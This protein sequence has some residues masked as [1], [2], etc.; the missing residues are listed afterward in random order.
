MAWLVGDLVFATST[1]LLGQ[2]GAW[3]AVD[4]V[5]VTLVVDK[6]MSTCRWSSTLGCA[7]G[8]ASSTG[9]RRL[10]NSPAATTSDFVPDCFRTSGTSSAVTELLAE[11]SPALQRSA[12]DLK[13][14]MLGFD[15]D[16][17]NA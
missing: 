9:L 1:D 10:Q 16:A 5:R 11:V 7:V 8:L 13:A 15:W 17:V 3:R 14:N 4:I 6:R 2:V 12:T